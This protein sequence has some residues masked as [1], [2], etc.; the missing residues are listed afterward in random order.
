MGDDGFACYRRVGETPC[1][2]CSRSLPLRG[3]LLTRGPTH[4]DVQQADPPAD[5][6]EWVGTT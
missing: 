2:D 4:G 6:E 1:P 3:V 5:P